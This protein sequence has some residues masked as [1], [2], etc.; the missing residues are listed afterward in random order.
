MILFS[1]LLTLS[2]V[3]AAAPPLWLDARGPQVAFNPAAREHTLRIWEWE[4][5]MA[6]CLMFIALCV[7]RPLTSGEKAKG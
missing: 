5:G 3:L 7:Q 2:S 1:W 4:S 6:P